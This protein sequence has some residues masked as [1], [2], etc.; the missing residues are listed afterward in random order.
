MYLEKER[1]Q[2]LF[3]FFSNYFCRKIFLQGACFLSFSRYIGRTRTKQGTDP[4]IN[5][6]A[7][8]ACEIAWNN[9]N[10]TVLWIGAN[11]NT[12]DTIVWQVV[13]RNGKPGRSSRITGRNIRQLA[14]ELAVAVPAECS[15]AYSND[16]AMAAFGFCKGTE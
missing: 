1:M 4:V 14:R 16:A 2:V 13:W 12:G 3:S 10:R 15:I 6:S 9:G 5:K 11:S 7:T 8:K